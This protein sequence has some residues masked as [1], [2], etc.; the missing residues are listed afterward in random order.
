MILTQVALTEAVKAEALELGFGRVAIGPADAPE[1][2]L[3]FEAWLA[4]GYAGTMDYLARSRARR[5]DL[6]QVLPGARSVIA[7]GLNYYQGEPS[8]ASGW[9]P[10][11]RYAWGRDYHMVMAPRLEKLLAFVQ[12][13][14]GPEIKGRIYVDTGPVLERDLAARAGLG[15]VGKNTNLLHPRL[16][17]FFFIGVILTTAELTLDAPLPDRC[18]TC[19]A[20]LDACPTEA[21][22]APYVLDARRCI[23]YLTIEHKGPI[24]RA[25]REGVGEWAFGCD[26]C[27]SV[28]P[29]NGKAPETREPALYPAGPLSDLGQLLGLDEAAF[30]TRFAGTPIMRAKRR[31]F[32]RNV[33][34]VLG[35]R[36]DPSAVPALSRALAD[37]DPL[38]RQH[39]AWALGRMNAGE[40][41]SALTQARGGERDP[42]VLQEMREA[43]GEEGVQDGGEH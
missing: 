33:A 27:Q 34:V 24:P 5:L 4:A 41:Q 11:A 16:G 43:L 38:V 26:L 30:R 29:W 3:A 21:F 9:T 10:V 1:H 39:V 12:E 40:A 37:P 25:L 13:A 17:S 2:G 20:C 31:G 14:G 18:G 23:A 7:V 22:V 6:Q 15:W 8:E 35:N 32:L 28:C 36:R 19:R 42:Q